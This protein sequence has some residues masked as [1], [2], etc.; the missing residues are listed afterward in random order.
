MTDALTL[1]P[2]PQVPAV[3]EQAIV[4]DEL[5]TN[6]GEFGYFN[7]ADVRISYT[8]R[9]RFSQVKLDE[10]AASIKAKGVAQPILIRP[11]EPTAE[12]P[13]KYEIVAG[14]RRFRASIIAGLVTIPAMLRNLSD[15]EALELQ[16]LENLQRDDPH[17]LEEAE[18]YERLMLERNYD[19][20]QL[21]EKLNKS[22]SYVYGRLKL[23]A[24]TTS[25]REQFLDD[26]FSAATAL[27][28]ARIPNPALQVK[29]AKE[30][31]ATNWDGSPL[32]YRAQRDILRN[33]FMLDLKNAVF[34]IKDAALLSDVGSCVECPKR[35][36]NQ[37]D[38]FEGEKHEH[39]C[40]D[41]DCFAEK[42]AAHAKKARRM[43]EERGQTVISGAEAKSIM[44][45]SY[46][47]L[48]GGYANV[49]ETMWVGGTQTSYRKL[50]GK[51]LPKS[52]MLESPFEPGKLITIAK[53]DELE[54]LVTEVAGSGK[55]EASI[56]AKQK[57]KEKQQEQAA[58]VEKLF[59]RELFVAIRDAGRIEHA[60][61]NE[62]EV[63]VLLFRN[64]PNTE[65]S[66]IRK[67]Y[68]WTGPEFESG[69]WD[70]KYISSATRIAE[71]IRQMS[72]DEARQLIRDLTF[73]RELEVSTYSYSKT[74]APSLMLAAAAGL[75]INADAIKA[76]LV[77]EAKQ[78]A[79]EKAA[80]KA[81]AAAKAKKSAPAQAM[82]PEVPQAQ[83][84]TTTVRSAPAATS[85]TVQY[86]NPNDPGQ[87]WTGR[88][89]QP[90]WVSEWIQSGKSLDALRINATLAATVQIRS[91]GAWPFPKSSDGK[92]GNDHLAAAEATS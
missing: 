16:I 49:D 53:I 74:D 89:K 42:T 71:A 67:L 46:G 82:L 11:V 51:Q 10:L 4:V 88:G 12:A 22:R 23:C 58:A 36:G 83:E 15:V 40:T 6:A 73:I 75:G 63:A 20:D 69:T 48:K 5:V 57:A 30:V 26:K 64:S 3:T 19:V 52:V 79:D 44:P 25:V 37:P 85:P 39:L 72:S 13:E 77:K 54:D 76:A 60:P 27:L 86:R 92:S 81:K 31:S 59:R 66:F 90:K 33:R 70:G 62:Q 29:A 47:K 61:I 34:Q 55:T 14:E 1:L 65:D 9:K 28:I 17:P 78:K 50:L 38:A 41:P 56:A 45:N 87:A 35:S 84:V 8:N 32:S 24:L 43:A 21:A 80:K 18:G 68:G 2:P 91:A 7:L